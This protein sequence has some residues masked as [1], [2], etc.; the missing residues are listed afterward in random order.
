MN[1]AFLAQ[2][3]RRGIRGGK[4]MAQNPRRKIC[5]SVFTGKFVA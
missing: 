2:N 3:L 5:D 1:D 4:M